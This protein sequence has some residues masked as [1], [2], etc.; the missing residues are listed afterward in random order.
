MNSPLYVTGFSPEGRPLIGGIF[1]MKD[2]EGFPLDA[3]F[4]LCRDK[5]LAID[6]MEFLCDAWLS[7]CLGFD[8]VIRELDML[9]GSRV[10]EWKMRGCVYISLNPEA[11]K[12]ENPVD[13]FCKYTL[14]LKR[15]TAKSLDEITKATLPGA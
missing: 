9:G 13:E 10:D 12:A 6:Y 11:M 1:K 14:A 5:G 7:D 3:S 15:A 2:Q 8:S 4:D